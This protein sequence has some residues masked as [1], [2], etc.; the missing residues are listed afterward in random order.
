VTIVVCN[1]FLYAY[2]WQFETIYAIN[3]RYTSRPF[4]LLAL[5]NNIYL[6]KTPIQELRLFFNFLIKPTFLRVPTNKI[7]WVYILQLAILLIAMSFMLDLVTKLP[8]IIKYFC[9]G[10]DFVEKDLLHWG[11]LVSIIIV[12]V[13]VPVLEEFL[14]RFYLN[15]LFGNFL[16]I[17]INVFILIIIL[18]GL[19]NLQIGVYIFISILILISVSVLLQKKY[20][21]RR[22]FFVLFKKHFYLGYYFSA[23]TFG[24]LHVNNYQTCNNHSILVVCLVLPQCFGGLVLGYTRLKHG[25]LS[26]ILVHILLNI[27]AIGFFFLIK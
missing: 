3:I 9:L 17:F 24:I 13:L 10:Q 11:A 21:F 8:F 1:Y 5:L 26:S 2:G 20:A 16:Y 12:G 6:L 4:I 18:H 23:L 19:T 25:I 27:I 22:R 7:V 14:F 15:K